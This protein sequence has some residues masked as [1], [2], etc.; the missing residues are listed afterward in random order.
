MTDADH[1]ATRAAARPSDASGRPADPRPLDGD[2]LR[3]KL[4][5]SGEQPLWRSLDELCETPEFFDFLHREFPRQAGEWNDPASRRS[6]LKLMAASLGLAGVGFSGCLRQPEEKI[7]SYVRQPEDAVPGKPQ[8][9]ATCTTLR[10]YATGILVESHLGRPTKIEGNPEHPASLGATSAFDQASILSLYD[11]D[12]SQTVMQGGRISTWSAFLTALTAELT[13]LRNRQG[14]GLVVMTETITSPAL[15]DQLQSLLKEMPEA[16]WHQ[17]EP[18][19]RDNVRAGAKLAFGDYVETI[20]HFDQADIVL[21][22]DAEFLAGMPGSLR[23]AREFVDRRRIGGEESPAKISAFK[24]NRL[25]AVE[26]TPGLTGAAADHR[27]PLRAAEV[28]SL[29]RAV[30]ARLGVAVAGGSAERV[31]SDVPA[32]WLTAL[33]SDLQSHRGGSLVIAGEGQPAEVHALAHAIN[34]QLDNVGRTVEYLAPVEAEPVDQHASLSE[35]VELMRQGEAK[36]LVVLGGN[37]VYNAPGELEFAKAYERVALRVHLSPYFDETSFLSHWHIPAAHELE[38]WGD[39]RAFDG[40][41]TIQQPLIAPLYGGRTAH[42][43]V[44]ALAAH[45][46]LTTYNIVQ[47]F[48]KRQLGGDDFDKHWRQAVHDGVVAGTRAAPLTPGWKFADQISGQD[49]SATRSGGLEISFCP[50]PTVWDGRFA[51]SGW[52]QELP[53]PITKLTWDNAALLSPRTAERLRISNHALVVLSLAGRAVQAPIWIVPGQPDD[54]ISLALGYGRTRAGRIGNDVGVSAY[55]LRPA[56]REWFAGGVE[57]KPTGERHELAVTQNH[58]SMEGRDLVKVRTLAQFELNPDFIGAEHRH[59]EELPTLYPK[60]EESENAWGMAIDQT[61]CIGCN[62][63]VVACQ[64]E[65]NIPI[66]GKEQVVIGREMHWLRIDRYYRGEI[67]APDT[68]FQPM[69]CVHCENAPCE[70]VCP[71]AATVHSHEGLNQMVYNRCV[72]TRYCSNNCPYKVRRFNFLDYDA[73]FD[74]GGDQAPS[75][76]L[77]RNPEVTV[78]SRGVMEK[79]TYCVQRINE[80]KIEAQKQGRPIR[81]GEITTACQQACPTR[82]IVFGNLRDRTSAVAKLKQSPLNYSL[83]SELNTLPR[84]SHLACIRNP[85]PDLEGPAASDTLPVE[86]THLDRLKHG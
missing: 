45:P 14:R 15:A 3:Q 71:V 76:T 29:T 83:L 86:P 70:L 22:L 81:D 36:L 11:P 74:Y 37:P 67:D 82:A 43:L 5:K 9:F 58:H 32:A 6:F 13:A 30:A 23:Y 80:A 72:G 53:G 69:M 19:G 84:T 51:N 60:Y 50:D 48:W 26:S 63:C 35:L 54:S 33:V 66:V 62:A 41:A 68:F 75:L 10:G 39:A 27:L 34:R 2:S 61:A 77:L 79:C 38:S 56:Q 55:D 21:A 78:R 8:Y 47:Q 12:R 42:E 18:A 16:R 24:M 28:E 7:V 57:L 20:Y 59:P 40:T 64:A 49:S 85:H 65:N 25:Y 1:T 73:L 44:A 31:P 46:E 4:S 17:Y 52:L